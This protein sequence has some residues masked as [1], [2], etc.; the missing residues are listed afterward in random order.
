MPLLDIGFARNCYEDHALVPR[1]YLNCGNF[2]LQYWLVSILSFWNETMILWLTRVPMSWARRKQWICFEFV[3][4]MRVLSYSMEHLKPL[5][6][7]ILTVTLLLAS[8][9][10]WVRARRRTGSSRKL[11]GSNGCVGQTVVSHQ[12]T[13]MTRMENPSKIFGEFVGGI[14]HSRDVADGL[15]RIS[16]L[17]L[18]STRSRSQCDGRGR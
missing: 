8:P 2:S 9:N 12:A 14:D 11:W 15:H 5:K 3:S 6:T 13:S 18:Q 1:I 4:T 17:E 16:N 10:K 7:Q